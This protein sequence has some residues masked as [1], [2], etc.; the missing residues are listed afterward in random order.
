MAPHSS[1]LPTDQS[2]SLSRTAVAN[3]GTP[4][5]PERAAGPPTETTAG[6]ETS[7]PER[8]RGPTAKALAA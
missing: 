1:R 2:M 8:E 5:G 7:P 6:A 3:R 4:P